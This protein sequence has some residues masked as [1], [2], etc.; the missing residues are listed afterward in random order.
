MEAAA[1]RGGL[2]VRRDRGRSTGRH[3]VPHVLT[4]RKGGDFCG[5]CRG[6]GL[7]VESLGFR[8]GLSAQ[9]FLGCGV[10]GI[11]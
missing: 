4:R 1:L 2:G 11:T 8:V 9:L 3:R 6:F 10:L 7:S 5:F